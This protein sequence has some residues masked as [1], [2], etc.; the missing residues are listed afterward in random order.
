MFTTSEGSENNR[1]VMVEHL[2]H[3]IEQVENGKAFGV[4]VVALSRT[5]DQR[6]DEV[7]VCADTYSATPEERMHFVD[8]ISEHVPKVVDAVLHD[9]LVRVDAAGGP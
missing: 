4:I 1:A 7:L 3:V 6:D 9:L 2:R 5:G 8:T